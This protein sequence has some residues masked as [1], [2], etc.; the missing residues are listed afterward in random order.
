[1]HRSAQQNDLQLAR[2]TESGDV[3]VADISPDGKYV[4]YVRQIAGERTLWLKQL[5]TE[6]LLKLAAI[7]SLKRPG[8]TFSPDGGYVYFVRKKPL[9]PSGELDRMAFPGGNPAKVLDGISGA[10]AISP[11]GLEI[12][13]IRSTLDTHG[14]DS[15]W[16][17]KPVATA[18]GRRTG[19]SRHKFHVGQ[20]LLFQM[21]S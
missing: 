13:F 10:P 8:L 9:E 12:A 18:N 1:V 6:R 7:G 19:G 11:D 5:S 15:I 3:E 17:G 4:A 16:R 21:E 14:E 20:N 2:V